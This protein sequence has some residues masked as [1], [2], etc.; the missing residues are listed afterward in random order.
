MRLACPLYRCRQYRK[1]CKDAEAV[2]RL[3]P[4]LTG[5]ALV[6]EAG[7]PPSVLTA[8]TGGP[9]DGLQ[10]ID[11]LWSKVWDQINPGIASASRLQERA[12]DAIA[13]L[14]TSE[15]DFVASRKALEVS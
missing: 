15:A 5:E 10:K 4:K 8:D 9:Q 13:D 7:P 11:A 2:L 3:G 1:A 6:P 14:R 12:T